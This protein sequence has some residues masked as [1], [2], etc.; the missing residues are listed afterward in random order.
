M[1]SHITHVSSTNTSTGSSAKRFSTCRAQPHHHSSFSEV[2]SAQLR[3]F[4]P[5]PS[6][7][8]RIIHPTPL[9]PSTVH[10]KHDR[11]WCIS[12]QTRWH[13]SLELNY[14]PNY[15]DRFPPRA[16]MANQV[17]VHEK[18]FTVLYEAPHLTIEYV[19]SDFYLE[20][21]LLC[22]ACSGAQSWRLKV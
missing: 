22:L 3:W 17:A 2:S 20:R 6:S 15:L 18:G 8:F 12:E 7:R 14:P 5:S 10:L 16:A 13:G 19:S 4:Q 9:K 11:F 21:M 1:L